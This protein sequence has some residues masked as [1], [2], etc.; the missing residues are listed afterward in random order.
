MEEEEAIVQVMK[1]ALELDRHSKKLIRFRTKSDMWAE[2][3]DDVRDSDFSRE[4]S[5]NET[6]DSPEAPPLAPAPPHTATPTKV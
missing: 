5:D 2:V 1:D 3:E 4:G 6:P